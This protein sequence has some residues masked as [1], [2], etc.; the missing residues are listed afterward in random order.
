VSMWCVLYEI[1]KKRCVVFL[2]LHCISFCSMDTVGLCAIPHLIHFSL[3]TRTVCLRVSRLHSLLKRFGRCSE[4]EV[5]HRNHLSP[6]VVSHRQQCRPVVEVE[7]E[8]HVACVGAAVGM[9]EVAVGVHVVVERSHGDEVELW[10]QTP[11]Q[12]EL[13]PPPAPLLLRQRAPVVQLPRGLYCLQ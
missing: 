11:L 12:H 2:S 5:L 10:R 6:P 13:V 8:V 1:Y 9:F 4:S 7:V 3:P